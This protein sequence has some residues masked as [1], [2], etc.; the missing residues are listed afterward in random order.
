MTLARIVQPTR[1]LMG[2]LNR[3]DDLLEAITKLCVEHGITVGRV[4]AIGAVEKAGLAY[5]DQKEREY[6]NFEVREPLEITKLS[7]NVSIK[8][9][10]PF[11]HAHV[12]LSDADGQAIGGHLAPG[13]VV[14]ACEFVIQE[15][16]GAEFVRG[17]DE[18]T[19]LTL[20][21]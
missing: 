8:D 12:T 9:G 7:G 6:Q 17:L 10:R 4:E 18:S 19:G 1:T 3:G 15:F 13:T 20:W 16:D 5:Y 21:A 11:V 2:R 14:F